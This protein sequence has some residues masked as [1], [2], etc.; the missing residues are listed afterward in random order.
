MTNDNLYASDLIVAALQRHNLLIPDSEL[1]DEKL[2]PILLFLKSYCDIFI[3]KEY[4][5]FSQEVLGQID[6][7]YRNSY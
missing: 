1:L 4:F 2:G 6:L 5:L 7:E 3:L